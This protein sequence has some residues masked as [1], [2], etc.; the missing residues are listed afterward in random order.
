MLSIES[1]V[2]RGAFAGTASLTSLRWTGY[3]NPVAKANR[4]SSAT[5]VQGPPTAIAA[6]VPASARLRT[7]TQATGD[8]RRL[9]HWGRAEPTASATVIAASTPPLDASPMPWSSRIGWNRLT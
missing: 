9:N 5:T 6:R 4:Q 8:R 7:D 2:A 3:T 1:S